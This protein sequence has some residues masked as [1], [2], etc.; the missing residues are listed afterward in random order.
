VFV[1]QKRQADFIAAFLSELNYPA[2]SI[3]GDRYQS[4]REQALRDF[5]T[6]KMS[7]LVATSVAAKG[8]SKYVCNSVR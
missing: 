3:H 2:T 7:I 8:L 5:R 6:K 1:Q 4:Q